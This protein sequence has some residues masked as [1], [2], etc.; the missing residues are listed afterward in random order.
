MADTH[1]GTPAPSGSIG[2]VGMVAA[3]RNVRSEPVGKLVVVCEPAGWLSTLVGASKPTFCWR[4][5]SL[6]TPL[7]APD[8]PGRSAY[9][10]D[11]CL[12]PLG[13]MSE[14]ALAALL[15]ADAEADFDEA[16]D[17]FAQIL[18]SVDITEHGFEEAM[19][20]AGDCALTV[21]ALEGVPVTT[22]LR[23][24]GF[25]AADPEGSSLSWIVPGC[26][27]E[28]R[29]D[30]A[31]DWFGGWRLSV[32]LRRPR[33]VVHIERQLPEVAPRGQ[34]VAL[35]RS[36]WLEAM[37]EEQA[38]GALR[39][40]RLY[41]RHRKDLRKVGLALPTLSL[42]AEVFRAVRRWIV[43]RH[44]RQG[45]SVPVRLSFVD[46]LLRFEVDGM[47]YGCPARGVWVDDRCLSVAALAPRAMSFPRSRTVTVS[48]EVGQLRFNNI[49]VPTA[50]A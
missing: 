21:H 13:S 27:T 3:L 25:R 44:D 17:D 35:V 10:P 24:V 19:H 38:P 18:A 7:N 26:A 36:M 20:R 45:S 11:R 34:I 6:G 16:L 47:A 9:V 40:G 15:R 22:A 28:A 41:D 39:V 46:G 29:F 12:V 37:P 43:A 4:V 14:E 23:E 48:Q 49:E 30:A 5:Q 8:K 2:R 32:S 50:I 42:D 33:E 31:Q 1:R